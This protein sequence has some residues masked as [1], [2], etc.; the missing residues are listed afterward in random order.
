VLQSEP[1]AGA[2]V[3]QGIVHRRMFHG[4]FIQ[5]VVDWPPGQ[6]LVRRPPTEMIA[7]GTEV[8]ISF[9][10]QHCILL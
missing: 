9:S 2:N 7:E 4:D 3:V 8:K 1:E 10:P 6:L 5:Y